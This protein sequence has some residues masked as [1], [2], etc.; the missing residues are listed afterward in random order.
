MNDK[1]DNIEKEIS[2]LQDVCLELNRKITAI[3][4]FIDLLAD[5]MKKIKTI[6]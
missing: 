1:I 2:E 5:T 4:I 3:Y 6:D